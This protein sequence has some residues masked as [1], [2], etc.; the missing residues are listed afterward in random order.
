MSGCFFAIY[1]LSLFSYQ[2]TMPHRRLSCVRGTK[3]KC[4]WGV[5]SSMCTIADT[6]FSFPTHWVRKLAALWKNACISFG[7]L[8]LK[9]SALRLNNV[10]VVLT[11]AGVKVGIAGILF[12]LPFVVGFQRSCRIAL[13]LLKS[14][15][16][17]LCHS[18]PFPIPFL[19]GIFPQ[20]N[21]AGTISDRIGIE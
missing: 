10:K 5:L 18:A 11:P 14:Q 9:N 17:V 6:I 21:P 16:C 20:E 15:N 1:R 8:L 4:R 7:G 2:G 3:V 19:S 13:V 12:F